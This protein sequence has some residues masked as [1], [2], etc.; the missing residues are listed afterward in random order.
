MEGVLP[1]VGDEW[2]DTASDLLRLVAQPRYGD[3]HGNVR[4]PSSVGYPHNPR[5]ASSAL[6]RLAPALRVLG[7]EW[8]PPP[9]G[10]RSHERK[11]T[12]RRVAETPELR[13]MS[14]PVSQTARQRACG[15]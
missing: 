13:M 12:L 2:C 11:M 4:I 15:L 1:N 10:G 14:S 5:G 3:P 7:I 8:T 9:A 6:R